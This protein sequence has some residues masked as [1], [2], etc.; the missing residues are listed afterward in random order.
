QETGLGNRLSLERAAAAV[1]G[2]HV[3]LFGLDRFEVLRNA[4]GYDVMA[5]LLTTVG[6]RLSGLTDQ[7]PVARVG[8]GV[9]GLILRAADDDQ[10]VADAAR[11]CE[12]AQAPVVLNGAPVDIALTAGLA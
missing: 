6:H 12:A 10:A 1:A 9:V 2:V 7:P 8:A 11:L 3:V 4:I 5:G